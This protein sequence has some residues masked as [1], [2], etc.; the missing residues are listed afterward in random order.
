MKESKLAVS[1]I[2]PCSRPE[3]LPRAIAL[4]DRQTY[5]DKELI[6]I[7]G[8]SENIPLERE[9]VRFVHC[10][11][12]TIGHRRNEGCAYSRGGVIVHL[13]S[14][15]WYAPDWIELSVDYLM[16]S[17]AE[18]VGLNSCF[19]YQPHSQAW[20]YAFAE[21]C[22][23]PYVL[24]ATMCYWK[25][26]WIRNK[27]DKVM[28]GEDARFAAAVGGGVSN[29]LHAESFVAMI[30]GRNTSSSGQV[31]KLFRLSPLYVKQILGEDAG[32]Y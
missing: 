9:D 11:D 31:N 2:M 1:C 22:K 7:A 8:S 24:G 21:G 18:L 4:F 27:F 29:H 10:S 17:G 23:M 19:F 13:D 16:E 14:D 32:L 25:N 12:P 26:T 30:H 20:Q 6:I 15:D 5:P 28:I 3:D